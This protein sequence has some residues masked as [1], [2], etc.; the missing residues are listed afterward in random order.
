LRSSEDLA[1]GRLQE[2]TPRVSLVDCGRM[3]YGKS[4]KGR[5]SKKGNRTG[6]KAMQVH[7]HPVHFLPRKLTPGPDLPLGNL[8]QKVRHPSGHQGQTPGRKV[9]EVQ[10]EK[11]KRQPP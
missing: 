6:G 7:R 9:A 2:Y 4:P 3:E 11:D 1:I 5:F 10:K 8:G